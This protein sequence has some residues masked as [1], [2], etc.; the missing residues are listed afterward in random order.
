MEKVSERE[1]RSLKRR[2]GVWIHDS[3]RIYHVYNFATERKKS[4]VFFL[5]KI[6]FQKKK[7]PKEEF[8][9]E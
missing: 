3:N 7:I 1:E 8:H 9:S 6:Q 2:I 5:C 4:F